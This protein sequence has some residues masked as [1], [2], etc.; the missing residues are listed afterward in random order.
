MEINIVEK[1]KKAKEKTKTQ[2]IINWNKN[3]R[4]KMYADI[5]KNKLQK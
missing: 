5:L 3:Y 4:L 1:R 2:K